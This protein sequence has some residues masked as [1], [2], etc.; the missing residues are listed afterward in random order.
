MKIASERYVTIKQQSL[1][2]MVTVLGVATG[3]TRL[4]E[5]GITE[6]EFLCISK[7]CVE[8]K[9]WAKQSQIETGDNSL[10]IKTQRCIVRGYDIRNS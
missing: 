1:L 8:S 7:N 10:P 9:I 2:G 3:Q 6:A 4:S 5:S